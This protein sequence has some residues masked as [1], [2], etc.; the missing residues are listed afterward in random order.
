MMRI[1]PRHFFSFSMS[2]CFSLGWTRFPGFW[3]GSQPHLSRNIPSDPHPNDTPR[4]SAM[5]SLRWLVKYL[6]LNNDQCNKI[7]APISQNSHIRSKKVGCDK[8]RYF[9]EIRWCGLSQNIF[10]SFSMSCCRSLGWT[11]FLGFWNG[12]QPHLSRN[13]PKFLHI[14]SG[15]FNC[16]FPHQIVGLTDQDCHNDSLLIDDLSGFP[17]R[18][19]W[20]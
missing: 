17:N 9:S 6:S 18:R 2:R 10:F 3:N 7:S 19:V 15:R 16:V 5:K 4:G 1:V 11:R 14:G 12:S 13:I 8:G 20:R